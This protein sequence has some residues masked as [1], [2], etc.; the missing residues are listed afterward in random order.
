MVSA[1]V[2]CTLD[3]GDARTALRE[4]LGAGPD[5]V[6]L[7]EWGLGR[8]DL[9]RR[10]PGYAWAVP[11]YGGTPVGVRTERFELLGFRSRVLG[12]LTRADRGVRA[13][14]AEPPRRATVARLHDRLHDRTV[15]VV[16]YHLVPGVQSRGRYREE[17]PRLVARHRTEVRRLGDLVAAELALGHVVLALGDSNFDGLRLPGLTSAW[18]GREHERPGTLGPH[19]KIDDVFGPG[20]A[21]S[22]DLLSTPSDHRA[23]V[24][25]RP[26]ATER[27]TGRGAPRKPWPGRAG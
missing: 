3:R 21:S 7:Q 10:E 13:F 24:V 15:S 8:R 17:R 20:P 19:R 9:L 27:L 12:R 18:A 1:N 26:D 14:P 6:G 2:L 16:N 4:V 23:V 11:L 25:R 5:V 22:V